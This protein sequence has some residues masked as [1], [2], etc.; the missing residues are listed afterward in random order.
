MTLNE[1]L[2]LIGGFALGV[3]AALAVRWLLGIKSGGCS[4]QV[5]IT[6]VDCADPRPTTRVRIRGNATP[7]G[8]SVV[9]LRLHSEV[10][11]NHLFAPPALPPASAQ[12]HPPPAAGTAFTIIHLSGAGFTNGDK[13]VVWG[14]FGTIS[15]PAEQQFTSCNVAGS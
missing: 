4:G 13:A 11:D 9:C 3:F 1:S 15:T 8:T 2:F 14:E 12:Q 7:M 10:Y 5:V 6:E